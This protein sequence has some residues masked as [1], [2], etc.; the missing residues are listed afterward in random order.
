MDLTELRRLKWRCRRGLLEND[1]VLER[2]LER[3]GAD[4]S[5][6]GMSAFAKLLELDDNDLRDLISGRA[7]VGDPDLAGIVRL[8]REC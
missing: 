8:L 7:E 6:A 1:I 4:L 3:H 2:F 5:G